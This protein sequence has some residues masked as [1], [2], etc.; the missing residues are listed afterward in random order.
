ME[1]FTIVIN[2][3]RFQ[4]GEA[5]PSSIHHFAVTSFLPMGIPSEQAVHLKQWLN[6]A[7]DR[8]TCDYVS[9]NNVLIPSDELHKFKL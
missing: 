4:L 5:L 8:I 2:N 3:R 7:I 6:T 1:P 9:F